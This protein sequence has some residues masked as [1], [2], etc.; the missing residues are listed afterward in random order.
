MRRAKWQAAE[1]TWVPSQVANCWGH[2]APSRAASRRSATPSGEQPS[3]LHAVPSGKRLRPPSAMPSG[4]LPLSAEP[5][6]K[7]P[8][9][10]STE[11]IS[12]PSCAATCH[13][14]APRLLAV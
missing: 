10:F 1:S 6:G 12:K 4:K 13:V 7:L 11:P 14:H 9:T 5:S 8:G 3:S 2:R